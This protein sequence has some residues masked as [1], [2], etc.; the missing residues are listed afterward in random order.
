[1]EQYT[2]T[3]GKSRGSTVPP[4]Q[5]QFLSFYACPWPYQGPAEAGSQVSSRLPLRFN[6]ERFEAA[7][8]AFLEN[9]FKTA[10]HD[11]DP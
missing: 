1:M 5:Q 7:I 3:L 9:D 6:P 11:I 4:Y 10:D 8:D 2:W